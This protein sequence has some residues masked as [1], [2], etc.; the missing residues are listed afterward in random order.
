MN[1]IWLERIWLMCVTATV[2]D[3]PF[4]EVLIGDIINRR[5]ALWVVEVLISIFWNPLISQINKFTKIV[6]LLNASISEFDFVVHFLIFFYRY[7]KI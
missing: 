2:F 6:I 7:I 1:S 5:K 3:D 4:F